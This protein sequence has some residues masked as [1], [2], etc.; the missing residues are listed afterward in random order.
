[1]YKMNS[2]K[3]LIAA[4][5]AGLLFLLAPLV[6]AQPAAID[7]VFAIVDD[8]V[9]LKSEFDVRWAQIEQQIAQQTGPVPPTAELRKQVL[10]QL[11]LEHLQ[12]QMAERAGVRVDDNLLNQ[13]LGKIA[14]QNNLSFEQFRQVLGEQGLYESTRDA[15]RNEIMI[16]QLQGGAVNRRIEISRQEIENYLRS[17][18]G[19][20]Q[21]APEY[22]AAQIFIPNTAGVSAAAQAE[23]AQ[24]LFQQIKDGANILG[25]IQ[26]IST[27]R[28]I[29]GIPLSGSDLGWHKTETLPSVFQNIVPTLTAGEVG[30]PFTSSNGHHIV[31]LLERAVARRVPITSRRYA[32]S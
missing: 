31:Q 28:Q 18:A 3:A 12:L 7:R 23:L 1:M 22:H 9:V 8:D 25:L 16:G 5:C 24:I 29:S 4:L 17:E 20:T 21:I 27:S 14:Q 19:A 10:D 26:E 6:Q 15:L 32:T 13:E 2:G 30:E 11:I